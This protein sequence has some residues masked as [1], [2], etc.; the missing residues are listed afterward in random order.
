MNIHLLNVTNTGKVSGNLRPPNIYI[1]GQWLHEMGFT[2][3]ALV[4]AV[5]ESGGMAFILCDESIFRYSELDASTKEQGGKL[6][7]AYYTDAKRMQCPALTMSGQYLHNAG[8]NPGDALIAHYDYGIIRVRKLP[9]TVKIV[10]VSSVKEQ[11]SGKPSPKLQ[12]TGNWLSEL[13]FTPNALA[14]VLSVPGHITFQLRDGSIEE[15]CDLVRYA[16]QHK[17]K[18]SQVRELATKGKIYPYIMVSGSC[19]DKAGFVT[20]DELLASYEYG[21]ITV[22]RLNL[23]ALGF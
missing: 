23:E 17:M 4:Q 3:G 22:R 9:N 7:Q 16:R 15:Y 1:Y 5:P 6:I 12:L 11:R 13:G 8:F 18:L 10:L 20:G 19:L 14:T 21:L 2:A